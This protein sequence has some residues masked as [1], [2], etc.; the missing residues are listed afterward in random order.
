MNEK[1][2]RLTM[3]VAEAAVELGVSERTVYNMTH[4]DDFPTVKI[5]TRTRIY[6]E[7]LRE[8]I[9]AQAGSGQAYGA[10][11]NSIIS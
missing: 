4:R 6:R 2:E 7:G 3:S 9:R 8:W 5:G 11:P 10:P 1:A